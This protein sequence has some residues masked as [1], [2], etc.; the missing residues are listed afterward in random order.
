[1]TTIAVQTLTRTGI[2]RIAPADFQRAV[3]VACAE[4]SLS[5]GGLIR[6]V[7]AG[8]NVVPD[9]TVMFGS[10][11]DRKRHPKRIAQHNLWADGRSTIELDV[12]RWWRHS[13]SPWWKIGHEIVPAL[14]HE[15][16]HVLRLPHS[17]DS[18]HVMHPSIPNVTRLR[19]REVALY[20]DT[21][22]KLMEAA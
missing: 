19:G 12:R 13:E 5:M 20:R 11:I 14:L 9:V 6:F 18:S 17:T 1:M 22:K 4:W 3:I 10:T 8:S 16:G 21:L 15:L 7:E 2:K